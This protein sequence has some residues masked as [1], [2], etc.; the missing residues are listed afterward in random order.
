MNDGISKMKSNDFICSRVS[1]RKNTDQGTDTN[2][3]RSLQ[4]PEQAAIGNDSQSLRGS[5]TWVSSYGWQMNFGS[6]RGRHPDNDKSIA[7][8]NFGTFQ[9]AAH[10]MNI[11]RCHGITRLCL[12]ITW[13][14]ALARSPSTS[15]D[16]S[17]TPET[18]PARLQNHVL[19]LRFV[20]KSDTVE[21]KQPRHGSTVSGKLQCNSNNQPHYRPTRQMWRTVRSNREGTPRSSS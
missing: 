16:A 20:A 5:A 18:T 13:R 10:V 19:K 21:R 8:V 11:R 1:S 12:Y 3:A 14:C 15:P 6:L 7:L 4:W 9:A 17:V 2:G